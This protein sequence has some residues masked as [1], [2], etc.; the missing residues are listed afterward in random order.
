MTQA[1]F[2]RYIGVSLRSG[3]GFERGERT[4]P[5]HLALLCEY[6]V[7]YGPLQ[8]PGEGG[9]E[10]RE[11]VEAGEP[12]GEIAAG[13]YRSPPETGGDRERAPD[14]AGEPVGHRAAES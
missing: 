5:R 7:R 1:D 12:Q 11:R 10:A 3:A 9:A 14:E 2:C 4:P 13:A 6:I 8:L